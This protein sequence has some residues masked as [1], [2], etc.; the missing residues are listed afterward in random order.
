M[1]ELASWLARNAG[2][3]HEL[4]T[5]ID[6]VEWHW[7]RPAVLW[8]G[9]ALLVPLG[10]WIARRHAARMPWLSRGRR[11]MLTFC[12]IGVLALLV[13][14]LAAPFVRLEET[15]EERPVVAVIRD[16]S[17]SMEIPVGQLPPDAVAGVAGA[18][19]LDQPPPDDAASV[20]A[21]GD[22]LADW[23]RRE[24]VDQLFAAQAET[25]L[26]QLSDAFEV[27]AYEVGRRPVRLQ[28]HG[29]IATASDTGRGATSTDSGMSAAGVQPTQAV[30]LDPSDTALGAAIELAMDD[31]SGRGLAAVVLVSDGVS[32]VGVE[33]IAVLRRAAEVNGGEPRAPVFAVPIGSVV[34][35]AD[36]AVVDLLVPAEVTL[37]DTVSITA[38]I[39]SVGLSGRQ[40]VVELRDADGN[41]LESR[42]LDLADGRQQVAFSWK[43]TA[44]GRAGLTVAVPSQDGEATAVNNARDMTVL[45]TTR[46]LKTLVVDD[47]ARWDTRFLDH[48]IRRDKGFEPMFVLASAVDTN[49]AIPATVEGWA[50]YDLVLLGDAP[51]RLLTEDCQ[52]TLVEAVEKRGVGVVFQPGGSHLPHDY[53][54]M[55]L[56][57]LFP[58]EIEPPAGAEAGVIEAP[59]FEPLSMV[60]TA[61][62]AMHSAFAMSGDAAGN[63]E[64]WSTMPSFFRAAAVVR[65]KPS[66]TVLAEIA[67]PRGRGT[68]PLVIEAPFGRGRT[69]WIG[70][71]ET[72]RWRRNVGDPVFWR[73]WGQAL[74]STGRRDDK[75]WDTSWLMVEPAQCE[76]GSTVIVEL[77]LVDDDKRPV[78]AGSQP[79]TLLANG[80][81][82]AI[83]LAAAERPG[84]YRGAYTPESVG[85][86]GLA[87]SSAAGQLAADLM[88]AASSRELARTAVDRGALRTLA[89]LTGGAV[90]EPD[91]FST[92]PYRLTEATVE[93]NRTLE[94]DVWDTWPVLVLLVGMYC[95][96]IGIRRLSGSA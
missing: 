54:G 22:R 44:V 4:A 38:A 73:F 8:I 61:R 23:T 64:F 72:F 83:E 75:P 93:T 26:R 46:T 87:A 29:G 25:T 48:A 42:P 62:G 31:A 45:V 52:R 50:A 17:A 77:N 40:T 63:R 27:R 12:R 68:I 51:T 41:V 10:I 32:T 18:V 59:D 67:D 11:R 36:V 78:E 58:V 84:L 92:L 56:A 49:D 7:A 71:D 15:I 47:V 21:I 5:R 16:N 1:S 79:V 20:T 86:H 39:R 60:V 57:T 37:D 13:F 35:P 53:Q 14:V 82:A 70:T 95:V 89:D 91:A 28:E 55:P 19:G 76:P 69:F 66:S 85:R 81:S 9:L 94:D 80:E 96:D 24:L 30:G 3:G 34:P 74:R 6:R 33:P 43:A 65:P 88:V 90:L 2:I